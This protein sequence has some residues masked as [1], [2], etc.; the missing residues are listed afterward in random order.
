MSD[1]ARTTMD[2]LRL[3][4]PELLEMAG[5]EPIEPVDMLAEELGVPAEKIVKLD[6]NENPYGPSPGVRQALAQF[7]LYHFYPDPEQRR[8]RQ[9]L[10]DYLGLDSEH[11]VVGNGSD[12]LLE[13]IARL[14]L[15]PGDMAVT[16][17]PTFDMYAF[18]TRIWGGRIVK[19]PRRPDFGLDLE[20]I[21]EAAQGAK[22]IFLASP[23]NPTGNAISAA[24]LEELLSM[25]VVVVIDEAYAEFAQRSFVEL[26]PQR[27]NLII[28]RTFSKW[29]GLAGLRA[30]YGVFPKGIAQLL[31]KVKAPYNL[32]VAAEAAILASL[33]DVETLRE[34]VE[35]ILGERERL[36]EELAAVAFLRPFPSEA[37]FIL[38]R[39]EGVDARQVWQGLRQRGILVRYFD[40]PGV[41]DCLRIT[42]GKPEHSDRLLAALKEIGGSLGA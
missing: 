9:A 41:E 24:E 21:G 33:A 40:A 22:L 15:S 5:Y 6:G 13:L 23:N 31:G 36:Q 42:V 8:V 12:E 3:V 4:R 11:I 14:F 1:P 32:N 16:C 30:G 25:G 2:P 19:V 20:A 28:L 18:V 17:V 10:A 7:D 37:N 29:A 38:C 27:Q 39:S 35:A 34:R 26:V